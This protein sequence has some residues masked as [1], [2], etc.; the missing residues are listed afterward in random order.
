MVLVDLLV[1]SSGVVGSRCRGAELPVEDGDCLPDEAYPVAVGLHGEP[2]AAGGCLVGAQ[3]G[4]PE[5]ACPVG[6]EA[7]V[8]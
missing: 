6:A 7:A 5:A 8:G 1:G 3:A 2:P 4:A